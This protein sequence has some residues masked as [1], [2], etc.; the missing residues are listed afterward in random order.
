M[1]AVN[2]TTIKNGGE[3]KERE[4]PYS[5]KKNSSQTTV[6]LKS[7]IEKDRSIQTY[8]SLVPGR[9]FKL[10]LEDKGQEEERIP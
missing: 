6:T 1:L 9:W 3:G 2:F 7:W 4:K 5:S 8:L 10:A